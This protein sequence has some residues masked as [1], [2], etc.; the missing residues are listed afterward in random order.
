MPVLCSALPRGLPRIVDYCR[1]VD[2]CRL[3]CG[4]RCPVSTVH[5]D[6]VDVVPRLPRSRF[7]RQPTS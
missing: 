2:Y 6:V 4:V 3:P 1:Q 5:H 7:G